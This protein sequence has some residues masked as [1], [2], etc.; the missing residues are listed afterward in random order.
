[1]KNLL[2]LVIALLVGGLLP[3]QSA[4]NTQLGKVLNHPMQATFVSFC[5]ALIAIVLYLALVRPEI[6][7]ITELRATPLIQ[8]TGGLYGVVFVTAILVITP[9]IG[10][11]NTL[12]A[13]IVGQLIVSIFLDHFGLLGLERYPVNGSRIIGCIGLM[14]SLLLVQKS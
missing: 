8:F 9:K 7:S 6:P 10:I 14:I 2:F 3:I 4:I 12:V 5:G 13:A 11:A 1:M